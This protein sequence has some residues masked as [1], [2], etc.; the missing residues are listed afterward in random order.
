MYIVQILFF[1]FILQIGERILANFQMVRRA[2]K[3]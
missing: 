3:K 1:F 2:L